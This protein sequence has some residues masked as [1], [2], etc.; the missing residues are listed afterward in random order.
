MQYQYTNKGLM[1]SCK[2]C[3]TLVQKKQLPQGMMKAPTTWAPIGNLKHKPLNVDVIFFFFWEIHNIIIQKVKN[4]L[5][6]LVSVRGPCSTT[7]PVISC[8]TTQGL[9]NG[10][11][12][13]ITCRSEWHTPQAAFS[14]KNKSV[15]LF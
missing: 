1:K 8:P 15:T 14:S 6:I 7:S 3:H 12:P 2:C 4:L 11:S 9:A 5:V 13:L 10:S